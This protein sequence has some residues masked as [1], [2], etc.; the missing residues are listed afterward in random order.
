MT[1]THDK[2]ADWR[3][4]TRLIRGGLSR[5]EFAET[6]EGIFM[7]SGFVYPSAEDA[8]GAFAGDRERFIYS[9]FSNPTVDMFQNRMA[10]LE[11]ADAARGTATGMA[12]VFAALMCFLK[13]G[14]RVVASRALFGS[15]HYICSTLLPRFGIES[16]FV[17]GTNLD[18]W[19][20]AL[21]TPAQAVFLETPS[22]PTLALVDLKAVCDMA[23][24]AGAR[25]VVDNVFATPIYQQPM[26]FGADIVMY[27]ATKHIDGQGRAL[28]GVV[29]CDDDFLE[30]H[31]VPFMRN[32]GPSMSPFNAWILMKGLE[33]LPM[34]VA[35]MTAAAGDIAEFLS[36]RNDIARVLYPFLE[37]HPQHA[38]AKRQ[39]SGGS[40]LVSFELP[41]GK[42]AAFTF[43][44][45]LRLVDISN[46]LGDSKSII[47]HPATTT[48]QRIGEEERARL[49]ISDG[50][51]RL[52]VGLED[53]EDLKEDIAQ[54]L[55]RI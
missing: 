46:N 45:S 11:G 34:R 17:D 49:G 23:H 30:E 9:R 35:A 32:T 6:C 16:V 36:G 42:D 28:G 52:S 37:S 24:K 44:N 21:A 18:E 26:K 43:Q 10:M 15:C 3:P 41:G 47:T 2:P 50:L 51:V 27:S 48:H 19:E 13:A 12:A 39:M 4:A 40:T 5:S 53:V 33:T 38:L 14:D 55:S 1:D 22:N 8:E 7:T 20:A 29:L 54:A 31:L 25:V